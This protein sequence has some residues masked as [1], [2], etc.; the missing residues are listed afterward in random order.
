MAE[1]MAEVARSQ[2]DE[3]PATIYYAYK[4]TETK[5]GRGPHNRLGTR[6][7]KQCSTRGCR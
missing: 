3:V 6:S 1:F 2:P 7:S 5:E 4:A